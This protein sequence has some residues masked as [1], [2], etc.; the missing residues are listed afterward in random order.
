MIPNCQALTEFV[1]LNNTSSNMFTCSVESIKIYIS[2]HEIVCLTLM[3]Y[4]I[5]INRP[6]TQITN[7][8]YFVECF[9]FASRIS[10]PVLV[11]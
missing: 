7:Y 8:K 10:A 11:H 3:L 6:V 5:S 1:V 4:Y 9:D 2:L